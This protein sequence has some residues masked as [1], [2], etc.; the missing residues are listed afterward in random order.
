MTPESVGLLA[1]NNLVLGKHSGKHAYHERLKQLGYTNL[2]P[3]TVEDLVAQFKAVADVKKT[4]TDEDFFEKW[5]T[6]SNT[7]PFRKV[8]TVLRKFCW[9]IG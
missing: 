3:E 2:D 9:K 1:H 6:H 8:S 5:N 4:V 7:H